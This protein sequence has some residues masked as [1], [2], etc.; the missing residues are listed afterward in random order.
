MLEMFF[1]HVVIFLGLYVKC[2]VV[3]CVM[4]EREEK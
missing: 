3:V 1:A 4:Q 2:S